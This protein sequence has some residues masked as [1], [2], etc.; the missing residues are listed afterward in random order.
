M[1]R[2]KEGASS[3]RALV[4]AEVAKALARRRRSSPTKRPLL[5]ERDV[6]GARRR[7]TV[8]LE[9]PEGTLLTPAARDRAKEVGLTIRFV[10][11][12]LGEDAEIQ[13][14]VETILDRVTAALAG[15]K[16]PSAS[17]MGLDAEGRVH[18]AGRVLTLAAAREVR[19]GVL[20]VSRRTAITPAAWDWLRDRGVE[21]VRA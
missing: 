8:S 10:P 14:L 17:A 18:F 9:V 6:E 11:A 13:R 16:R 21:V 5:T 7:G 12:R 1:S 4:E 20:V 2:P 3:L 15:R 19:A